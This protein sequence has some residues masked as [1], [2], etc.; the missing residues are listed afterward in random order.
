MLGEVGERFDFNIREFDSNFTVLFTRTNADK[1][2][3]L[4][5][6]SPPG[7][8]T[9]LWERETWKRQRRKKKLAS[10]WKR[11]DVQK[12]C[13]WL[14][15]LLSLKQSPLLSSFNKVNLVKIR[16]YFLM[17]F[18]A[19]SRKSSPIQSASVHFS[20]VIGKVFV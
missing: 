2:G 11:E 10:L 5:G 15:S 9:E 13:L 20:E 18:A 7:R 12:F 6:F 16:R 14:H 17:N 4:S 3:C 8:T 19:V 1:N